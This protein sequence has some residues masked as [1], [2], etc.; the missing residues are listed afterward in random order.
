MAS[1][2]SMNLEQT[3]KLPDAKGNSA[4]SKYDAELPLNPSDHYANIAHR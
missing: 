3:T 2:I 1:R 4:R